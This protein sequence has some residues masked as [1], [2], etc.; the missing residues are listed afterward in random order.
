MCRP[1]QCSSATSWWKFPSVTFSVSSKDNRGFCER[2]Q[3][4][5][6]CSSG[7]GLTR[8]PPISVGPA[9]SPRAPPT[10][11]PSPWSR[12]VGGAPRCRPGQKGT[13]GQLPA[14]GPAAGSGC[15]PELAATE[16]ASVGRQRKDRGVD[17]PSHPP[18]WDTGPAV[19]AP[20]RPPPPGSLARTP[21]LLKGV[22]DCLIAEEVIVQDV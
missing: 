9:H 12:G 15:W 1:R 14:R 13:G 3:C 22:G 16:S 6:S 10:A 17:T 8:A 19:Q 2:G 4:Y 20:D 18:P 5:S 7:A 11:P 21:N